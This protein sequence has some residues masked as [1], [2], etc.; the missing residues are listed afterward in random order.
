M[1]NTGYFQYHLRTV[2]HCAD[3][4]TIRIPSLFAGLGAKR[5][6]LLSDQGLKQAGIVDQVASV[7]TLDPGASG[8]VLAGVYSDIAPDAACDTINAALNYAR[9]IAADSILAVGGGSVLDAAKGVKYAL[10]HNLTDVR[11][12]I[13][14]GIK[15]ESWPDAQPIAIPHIAVP[16]T[17][18]TGAEVTAVGVLYNEVLGIKGNLVAPFIEADMAVLDASLTCGLPP[19][20]TAATGMDA[21]TH[22][23]EAVTSPMANYFTDAHSFLAGKLIMDK[24]PTAVAEGHDIDARSAMLQG[25]TMACN[26]FFNALNAA[27]VHNCAHAFG[28]LFHIP[29][30]DANATLLPIVMAELPEYYVPQAERL[31]AALGVDGKGKVG[32]ELLA[33]VIDQIATLRDEIGCKHDFSDYEIAPEQVEPIMAAIATDPAAIFYPIPVDAIQRIV[34]RAIGQDG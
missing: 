22:A 33:E 11:D 25:S 21:L 1:H 7:F 9:E 5:V 23:V 16:T 2:V 18:G 19:R 13:Q 10:H 15:L 32:E 31:A 30:G 12:A 27:P 26:A 28:A 3:G 24:L 34:V 17:A 14:S 6:L 29:H 4:A 20:I 8:P